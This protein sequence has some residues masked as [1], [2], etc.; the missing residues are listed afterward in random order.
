MSLQLEMVLGARA[1]DAMRGFVIS[2][3][4]HTQTTGI[5]TMLWGNSPYYVKGIVENV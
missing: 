1:K 5:R 3:G 4:K 2:Q